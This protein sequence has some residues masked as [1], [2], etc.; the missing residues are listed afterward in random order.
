M[1]KQWKEL[2]TILIK[3]NYFKNM[4]T[5]ILKK[6]AECNKFWYFPQYY[7]KEYLFGLIGGWK[8]FIEDKAMERI[9]NHTN[10]TKLF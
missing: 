2:K 5:R 3:L 7:T 10:Q 8:Y 9:K 6:R 1:I 4:K